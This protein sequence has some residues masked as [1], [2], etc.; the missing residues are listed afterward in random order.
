MN[1]YIAVIDDVPEVDCYVVQA[2]SGDTV[3]H[4]YT[5]SIADDDDKEN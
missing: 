1:M 2:V 4:S 5:I 3:V